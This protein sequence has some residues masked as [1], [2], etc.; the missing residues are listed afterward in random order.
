MSKYQLH[1]SQP[2]D[3]RWQQMHPN[4]NGRFCDT[5]ERTVVDFTTK[6][7]AQIWYEIEAN[8]KLCGRFT[9]TQLNSRFTHPINGSVWHAGVFSLLA[10]VF[11]SGEAQA[12]GVSD[13]PQ[14]QVQK[15]DTLVRFRGRVMADDTSEPLPYVKIYVNEEPLRYGVV[16]NHDGE[17]IFEMPKSYLLAKKKV[18]FET[19]GYHTKLVLLTA[20]SLNKDTKVTLSS[21]DTTTSAAIIHDVVD[22]NGSATNNAV[23]LNDSNS[24][25]LRGVVIENTGAKDPIPMA[26]VYVNQPIIWYKCHTDFDGNF[27]L[28]IPAYMM[29]DTITISVRSVGYPPSAMQVVPG[30]LDTPIH[31]ELTLDAA[32]MGDVV[33]IKDTPWLRFKR[34]WHKLWHKKSA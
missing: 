27:E 33:I 2:C 23:Q 20:D 13:W 17:F 12:N 21:T 14:E 24:I 8:N 16:S 11:S 4:T 9:R 31:M 34:W 1:I 18:T 28:R 32:F 25:L 6:S 15:A 19:L 26:N 10:A 3:E 30:E 22:L 29:N 5:C 7:T